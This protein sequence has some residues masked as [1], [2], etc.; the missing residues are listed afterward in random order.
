[1]HWAEVSIEVYECGDRAKVELPFLGLVR[2]DV[3]SDFGSFFTENLLLSRSWLISTSWSGK[4]IGEMRT[5]GSPS[6]SY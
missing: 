6:V 1:V 5:F 3:A 4:F 2:M